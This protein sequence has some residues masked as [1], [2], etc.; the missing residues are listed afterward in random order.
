MDHRPTIQHVRPATLRL[1]SSIHRDPCSSSAVKNSHPV[2]V[3]KKA[4]RRLLRYHNT[5]SVI[6]ANGDFLS[7]FASHA[8]LDRLSGDCAD[9]TPTRLNY[10]PRDPAS[11]AGRSSADEPS[12]EHTEVGFL[13]FDI[14]FAHPG[15]RPELHV[16]H[17]VRL[18]CR[19]GS[20]R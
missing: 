14:H 6:H 8:F 19:N 7:S 2:T 17:G 20:T 9:N 13:S 16:L 12:A 10:G 3:S 15:N 1:V 11:S 18:G 4:S 5:A